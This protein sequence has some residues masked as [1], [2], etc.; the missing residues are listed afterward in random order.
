MKNFVAL[1]FF[2]FLLCNFS[3]ASAHDDNAA[4]KQSNTYSYLFVNGGLSIPNTIT[5]EKASGG[6]AN[7]WAE[8]EAFA[9]ATPP[10]GLAGL[11]EDSISDIEIA[12]KGRLEYKFGWFLSAGASIALDMT[13]LGVEIFTYNQKPREGST[14]N[15][16]YKDVKLNNAQYYVLHKDSSNVTDGSAK[17]ILDGEAAQIVSGSAT[18]SPVTISSVSGTT[19]QPKASNTQGMKSY[20]L[21]FNA[22]FPFVKPVQ[23]VGLTAGLGIGYA[24]F[25]IAERKN[26]K[27]SFQLKGSVDIPIANS[28]SFTI[29]GRFLRPVNEIF[30]G[31]MFQTDQSIKASDGSTDTNN[32]AKSMLVADIRA[33]KYQIISLEMGWHHKI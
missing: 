10:R 25:E 9:S 3:I 22:E 7:A 11:D 12:N 32:I 18:G 15:S 24:S 16:L 29:S 31:I 20:G 30:D 1:L 4:S 27:F 19:R 21:M 8:G 33:K 2:V 6:I 13:N 14:G 28:G 17:V 5:L 23:G 26:N